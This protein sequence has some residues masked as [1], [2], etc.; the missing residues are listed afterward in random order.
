MREGESQPQELVEDSDWSVAPREVPGVCV[1][2]SVDEV[3]GRGAIAVPEFTVS[4]HELLVLLKYWAEIEVDNSFFPFCCQQSGS[5]WSRKR[6][7]AGKRVSRIAEALGDDKLV[8][9]AL[10]QVHEAYAKEQDGLAWKVFTG[11][12]TEQEGE[13]FRLWQEKM[14]GGD[15][16][17]SRGGG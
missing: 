4:R 11:K 8:K 16:E 3:N 6:A 15:P 7:F 2:G 5:D 10:D 17:L 14:Y 9:E 1:I 12:A 13:E